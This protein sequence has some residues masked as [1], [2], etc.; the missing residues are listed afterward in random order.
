MSGQ[1]LWSPGISLDAMEKMI[2]IEAYRFFR[3]N[4]TATA[5]ALGISVRT[6]DNKLEKY[7][8]EQVEEKERY[9][10]EVR[11]R[12]E[13]LLRQRGNPPN[14]IGIPYTPTAPHVSGALQAKSSAHA[15][16]GVHLESIANASE[17]PAVSLPERTEVQK[18]LPKQPSPSGK[19]KG[20]SQL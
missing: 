14:N 8:Q 1:I 11:R 9:E 19:G 15:H 7:E 16:A 4:K 20:R 6:L 18:V 5:S 2:I 13:F 17:K 10:N 3:S 12:Q